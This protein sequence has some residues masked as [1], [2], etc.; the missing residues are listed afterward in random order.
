[1]MKLDRQQQTAFVMARLTPPG[2]GAVAVVG[3]RGPAA[4]TALASCFER[5]AQESVASIPVGRIVFGRWRSRA[6]SAGEEVVVAR[7]ADADWE[8]HCHGGEA[9]VAAVME[10]L[11]AHG[12][13]RCDE[14]AWCQGACQDPLAAAAL[15]AWP[16]CLTERT[17]AW[18]AVQ[19]GGAL[20]RACL[21][22]AAAISAADA[23]KSIER[24]D[25]LIQR[26]PCGLRLAQPWQVA[27]V[28]RPNAGKSSLINVLVGYERA[29]VSPIPGTTRDVVVATTAWQGWPLRFADTAG[30]RE[31]DDGLEAA[32]IERSF[33][34]HAAADLTVH[35]ADLSQ[36]WTS[37]DDRMM[38]SLST[39]PT[40]IVHNKLD[41]AATD[42]ESAL[43][44]RPP[45]VAVSAWTGAG[46][47]RLLDAVIQRL[48]PVPPAPEDAIPFSTSI[49]EAL[50]QT[51]AFVAA[52]ELARAAAR[53][54]ELL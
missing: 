30:V 45:G 16:N 28:G 18:M 35:V 8:V 49:V 27:L 1:M 23:D 20:R 4:V 46:L 36:P 22:I 2:R 32:G 9:A 50:G 34:S 44:G 43:A 39:R 33:A 12:A 25:T 19:A 10:A 15:K 42:V 31:T 11:A 52:G 21:Q 38:A 7:V 13:M 47:E 17:S 3:L 5:V 51:R 6:S 54:G 48:V 24:L 40:L 29:I 41:L 26:A 37:E 14:A 53:L